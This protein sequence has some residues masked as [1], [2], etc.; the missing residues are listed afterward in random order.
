MAATQVVFLQLLGHHGAVTRTGILVVRTMVA[1]LVV[2]IAGML[3][4]NGILVA[5]LVDEMGETAKNRVAKG[6]RTAVVMV[7][8]VLLVVL[9]V[10]N[11]PVTMATGR[12]KG[13]EKV[14]QMPAVG[15]WTVHLTSTTKVYVKAHQIIGA[16]V[17]QCCHQS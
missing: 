6:S 14:H 12:E 10:V 4:D 17:M 13:A 8:V 2:V 11:G 3:L 1:H 7:A 5:A 16:R 9:R 15:M